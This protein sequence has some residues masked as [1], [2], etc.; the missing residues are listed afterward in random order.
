MNKACSTSVRGLARTPPGGQIA[1]MLN[2]R[3][4]ALVAL[5]TACGGNTKAP[6]NLAKPVE[7]AANAPELRYEGRIDQS[8]PTSP[9]FELPGSAVWLRFSGTG[10]SAMIS[11]HSLEKDDYGATAHNWYDVSI[12]GRDAPPFQTIEG[13]QSV[14]L[15]AGLS[16]GEHQ[17]VLRKRTEAYVG[18]G[19]LLGFELDAGGKLLPAAPATRRIEF[20][21]DSIT[22]GYGVDGAD[23]H[24]DFSAPTENYSHTYAALTAHALGAEQVAVAV[25][26]AGVYRNFDSSSDNT[27]GDLYLRA[28]PTHASDRWDFSRWTPDVVVINLGTNDFYHGDPGSAGFT[29]SYKALIG[30]VRTNYPSALIVVALGPM[31]S[32]LFPTGVNALTQARAYVTSVVHDVN[33]PKVKMI[34]FPNQ[35]NATSF[36]CRYHPSAATQQQMAGQLTQ[37]LQ[38]QLGW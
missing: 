24:C 20:I 10:A 36:G 38:Q 8:T 4:A 5:L 27:M 12:D 29:T 22:A 13:V 34:E 15:A 18:E 2:L 6:E 35:D 9:L 19:R 32:D 7:V 37:Y 14:V 31:L 26:G 17:L 23:G 1:I 11:E 28:L 25:T 21:G 30:R 3:C 16:A 33:D